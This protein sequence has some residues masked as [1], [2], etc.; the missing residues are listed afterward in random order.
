ML[1]FTIEMPCGPFDAPGAGNRDREIA[2][3]QTWGGG[4]RGQRSLCAARP[5]ERKVEEWISLLFA[6]E[7]A[8]SV[9][10]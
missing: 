10:S 8:L 2:L 6:V 5:K 9:K 7:T 4:R 1:Y 3:A